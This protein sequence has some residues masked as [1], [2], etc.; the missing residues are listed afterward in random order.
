MGGLS[1]TP[2]FQQIEITCTFDA[3]WRV[4][5]MVTRERYGVTLGILH[6]DH[7]SATTTQ[8]FSYDGAAV[9]ISAYDTYF[10]RY[11]SGN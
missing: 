4:L 8:T 7:C 5:S 11:A 10:S 6:A 2:V 1:D 3:S 9:D